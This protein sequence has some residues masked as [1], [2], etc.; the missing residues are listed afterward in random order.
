MAEENLRERIAYLE[1]E[2]A[3]LK[4]RW[5]VHSVPPSMVRRLEELEEE[6]DSLRRQLERDEICAQL[7][8]ML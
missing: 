8:D 7:G 5:P 3:E 6:C 2:L 4:R 1:E